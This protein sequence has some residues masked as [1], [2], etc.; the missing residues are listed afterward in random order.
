MKVDEKT[1]NYYQN[2]FGCS[3]AIL[4]AVTEE[5]GN[6]EKN[7]TR[8]GTGFLGGTGG[9]HEEICGALSGGILAVG[10]LYGREKKGENIEQVKN[11]VNHFREQF[12]KEFGSSNCG[13]L[14]DIFEAQS[15]RNK[16]K[17]MTARASS[18]LVDIINET[19]Q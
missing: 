3:E 2:G 15:N 5:F 17:E 9:S 12:V 4:K 10:Y 13:K 7:I 11:I 18:M 8:M 6:S 1:L 19:K 16:C 14:L